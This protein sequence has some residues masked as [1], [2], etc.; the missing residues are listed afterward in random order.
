MTVSV[1]DIDCFFI[2][3]TAVCSDSQWL[4]HGIIAEMEG[5]CIEFK[6][7]LEDLFDV[8]DYSVKKVELV[9]KAYLCLVNLGNEFLRDLP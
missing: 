9:Q 6:L 2:L 4:K 8:Q 3:S 7:S 5:R 1:T